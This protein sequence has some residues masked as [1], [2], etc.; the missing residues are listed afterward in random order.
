MHTLIINKPFQPSKRKASNIACEPGSSR[1]KQSLKDETNINLIMS[2]YQ[3]T[4]VINFANTTPPTYDY[5][6][7]DDYHTSL[8]LI[9]SAQSKFNELPSSVRNKF[10]NDPYKFLDYMHDE[11]KLEDSYEVGLRT[12]PPTMGVKPSTPLE[13]QPSEEIK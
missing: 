13:T 7:S 11:T 1:T 12:R 5:A 8:N 4:G 3:K 9:T 2:K 6:S 10:H